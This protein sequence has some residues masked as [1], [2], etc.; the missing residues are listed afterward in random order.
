[1]AH[2]LAGRGGEAGDVRDDGLRHLRPDVA[3]GLLLLVAADLADHDDH[4]G[5]VVGL[6]L[7]EDVDERRADDRIAADPDDRRVAQAHL[8]ELVADLVRERPRAA[9][10]PDSSLVQ[11]LRRDD[12]DVGLAGR[13]RARAIRAEQGDALGP[14]VV[15]DPQHVV[16]GQALRD[17]D[18]GLDPGVDGLVDRVH[19]KPRR[20]EDDGRVGARF[21]DSP[22]HRVEDR[23]ALD[24]LAAL[25]GRDPGD[26]VR[27]VVPVPRAVE[28]ALAPG[29][30]LDDEA[31]LVRDDDR[32]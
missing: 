31:R 15:V 13:E 20:D 3:R 25:A 10:E 11:D 4:V 8:G 29:Q 21:V 22:G 23:N 17:A 18:H 7:G 2:R 5:L 28:R 9:D 16:R 19:G 12:P 24:V 1:M 30:T 32:H 27:P 14:D 6:E 26:D